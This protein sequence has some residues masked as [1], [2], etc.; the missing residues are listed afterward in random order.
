MSQVNLLERGE[1]YLSL[2]ERAE[3]QVTELG[4]ASGMRVQVSCG[5]PGSLSPHGKSLGFQ[6]SLNDF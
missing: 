4:H 6:E 2:G 5:Q 3:E 1:T